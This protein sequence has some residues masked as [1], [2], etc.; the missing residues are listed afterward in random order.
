VNS[1]LITTRFMIVWVVCTF[2][3]LFAAQFGLHRMLTVEID[4]TLGRAI[5][6]VP[7]VIFAFLC[8]HVVFTGQ[9]YSEKLNRMK[10]DHFVAW[11]PA[12]LFVGLAPP[13]LCLF[14]LRVITGTV[15][16]HLDG[17]RSEYDLEVEKVSRT[18][19]Y[20]AGCRIKVE[21][22]AVAG[23]DAASFCVVSRAGAAVGPADLQP[24]EKIRVVVKS[25]ALGKVVESVRRAS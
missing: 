18:H 22:R 24:A 14:M 17:K 8:L 6:L 4:T 3:W 19:S 12:A 13:L 23:F 10:A 2:A 1:R 15:A 9:A 20:K 21:T 5:I 25:T 7:S 16:E 11:V